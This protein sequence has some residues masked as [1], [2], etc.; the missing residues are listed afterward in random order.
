MNC[1]S[2][3]EGVLGA[4][5][6]NNSMHVGL[7][8]W[9]HGCEIFL[10]ARPVVV[11]DGLG[12]RGEEPQRRSCHCSFFFREAIAAP[13]SV[14][15]GQSREISLLFRAS[16]CHHRGCRFFW[17]WSRRWEWTKRLFSAGAVQAATYMIIGGP[18]CI[19]AYN[20]ILCISSE[21]LKL[22][23]TGTGNYVVFRRTLCLNSGRVQTN[24]IR[25]NQLYLYPDIKTIYTPHSPIAG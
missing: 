14:F 19:A 4:D 6:V 25:N 17:E 24:C 10:A 5:C 2:A 9:V 16:G 7:P 21:A 8:G 15:R 23:C 22:I 18:W 11:C 3:C 12:F 20:R 1:F 13:L